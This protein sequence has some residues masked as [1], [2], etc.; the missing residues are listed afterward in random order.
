MNA[1]GETSAKKGTSDVRPQVDSFVSS[2]G[3]DV[4]YVQSGL[5]FLL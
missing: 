5:R 4:V 3:L 1:N 2:F